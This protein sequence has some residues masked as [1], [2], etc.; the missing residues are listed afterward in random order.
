MMVAAHGI[1][2]YV[3]RK[4]IKIIFLFSAILFNMMKLSKAGKIIWL[5]SHIAQ[6]SHQQVKSQF[7]NIMK[8]VW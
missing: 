1:C 7:Q 6:D 2:D 8:Q 5:K 4:R 3:L